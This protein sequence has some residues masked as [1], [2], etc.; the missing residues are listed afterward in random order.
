MSPFC[1]LLGSLL[2]APGCGR[3]A[4]PADVAVPLAAAEAT[5]APGPEAIMRGIAETVHAENAVLAK[6]LAAWESI[7]DADRAT[8]WSALR[9]RMRLG[10]ELTDLL[11]A[12]PARA[13]TVCGWYE[14]LV[15]GP[16]LERV[17]LN[18]ALRTSDGH[19]RWGRLLLDAADSKEAARAF[20][21]WSRDDPGSPTN[22]FILCT[23]LGHIED[24]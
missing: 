6:A 16:Y 21:A 8:Y 5:P 17:R 11:R 18:R 19:S 10:A 2:A 22:I 15:H 12:H 14:S 4:A 1:L 3:A 24:E 23:K 7:D 9:E 13:Q 20:L